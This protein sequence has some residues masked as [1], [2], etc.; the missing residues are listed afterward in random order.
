MTAYEKTGE[1]DGRIVRSFDPNREETLF[2][3]RLVG[4]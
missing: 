1:G 4:G 2:R 3:P